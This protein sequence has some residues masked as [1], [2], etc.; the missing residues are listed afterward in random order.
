MSTR[1][2]YRSLSKAASVQAAHDLHLCKDSD[3][4]VIVHASVQMSW[5]APARCTNGRREARRHSR[6]SLSLMIEHGQINLSTC[7]EGVRHSV[8]A[9]E[10][11]RFLRRV[12]SPHVCKLEQER[13]QG[14]GIRARGRHKRRG[15]RLHAPSHPKDLSTSAAPRVGNTCARAPVARSQH[16]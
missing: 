5:R 2:G 14:A 13:V 10:V 16:R 12:C 1:D 3:P 8:L 11:N 6:Q 7:D 15:Q 9:D 4:T